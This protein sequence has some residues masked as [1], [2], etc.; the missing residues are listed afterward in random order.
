[1]EYVRTQLDT[2]A[3]YM[4]RLEIDPN[5]DREKVL[6]LVRQPI[7]LD[8]TLR[9]VTEFAGGEHVASYYL[10]VDTPYKV[11]VV[12][13]VR[14]WSRK[15]LEPV[16]EALRLNGVFLVTETV[17]VYDRDQWE[18]GVHRPDRIPPR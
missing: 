9:E 6:F 5:A 2:R 4:S 7:L 3:L 10:V 16:E 14:D 17:H 12:F 1:M 8:D 15:A 13:R 11:L 18:K